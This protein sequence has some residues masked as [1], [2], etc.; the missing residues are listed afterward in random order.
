MTKATGKKRKAEPSTVAAVLSTAMVPPS[1][2]VGSAG[3]VGVTPKFTARNGSGHKQL[4]HQRRH[5]PLTGSSTSSSS[6]ADDVSNKVKE[7]KKKKKKKRRKLEEGVATAA[8]SVDTAEGVEN[9]AA[10]AVPAEAA[11]MAAA[12]AAPTIA[13]AAAA[14]A[15]ASPMAATAAADCKEVTPTDV[16]SNASK[17][18]SIGG[19]TAVRL[20]GS[21]H[22]VHVV[23]LLYSSRI[24]CNVVTKHIT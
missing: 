5:Q 13:A 17:S 7:T 15:L 1:G 12:A 23:I 21:A 10:K 19:T 14:P 4:E 20:T 3:N 18:A 9:P 6:P 8:R 2:E 22:Q 24:C 16:L 11:T